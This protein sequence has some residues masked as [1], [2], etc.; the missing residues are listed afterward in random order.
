M[1][2]TLSL[3]NFRS[4]K[5][6][7]IIFSSQTTILIGP[8]TIGKTNIIEAIF[9][10]ST[11]KSFRADKDIEMIIWENQASSIKCQVEDQDD[12]KDLEVRLTTG[13]VHG[14][15]TPYKRYLINGVAKRMIDFVG[16]L[17]TVLF[18]PEH[19]E[20]ISDSPSVRRRYLDFVLI[21]TDWEY[22]RSLVSY[23]KGLRQRNSLLERIRDEGISRSQLLFWD[24]LLIKNGSYISKKRNEFINFVNQTD[25]QFMDFTIYYDQSV[26][27][28]IR[29]KQY[30]REEVASAMTLVGPHRDD[31][32]FFENKRD[33]AKYGSRGEQRLT[34]LWLKMAEL[35]F[36]EKII[37]KRPLLLLD[38]IFSELDHEHR[39][40]VVKIMN[41]QQTILTTTDMHFLPKSWANW[42]NLIE[43]YK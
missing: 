16:N 3:K 20:L 14:I 9:L 36:V 7:D 12:E 25:K 6:R 2:K 8:N 1:L 42:G 10:L 26:I 5:R 27:S 24:Q 11:G 31:I 37:G 39:R 35:E 43:L 19:L 30:E 38:D 32:D 21:Q 18:W 33:L 34:I 29:L 17:K 41:R 22:R 13:E 40:E 15:K 4:Y 23:E 28:E